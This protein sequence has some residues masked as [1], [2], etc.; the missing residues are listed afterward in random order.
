VAHLHIFLR[1]VMLSPVAATKHKAMLLGSAMAA[2]VK[3]TPTKS[4]CSDVFTICKVITSPMVTGTSFN[5]DAPPEPAAKLNGL[6]R[7]N[8]SPEKISPPLKGTPFSDSDQ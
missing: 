3:F 8:E 7:L 2:T 4:P 1:N 6:A 5:M